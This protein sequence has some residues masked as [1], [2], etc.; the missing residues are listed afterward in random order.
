MPELSFGGLIN[1]LLGLTSGFILFS[2]LYAYFI[3]RGKNLDLSSIHKPAESVDEEAL[4][5]LILEKQNA[6]KKQYR[7]KTKG[8]SKLI[9]DLSFELVDEI[10]SYHFPKSKY[11]MLELSID[12]MINL[13]HY[14]TKRVNNVLEQPLLKN[15]RGIRVTKLVQLFEKKKQIEETK[16]MKAATNKNLNR[17]VKFTLGAVNVFN[18]AYWFRKL[19]IGTSVD[20]ITKRIALLTIGIVGEE[21]SKV[22]SKK[23]FDK[24]IDFDIVDEEL[25]ALENGED[26]DND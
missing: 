24:E 14:I 1:F 18:P 19:V 7:K 8:Y 4:K 20:F 3:V 16:L 10:A 9:Y 13:N 23:L 21:T 25:K 17:A 5:Q 12:E 6:F 2:V 26:D 22:Y 15:T 11:P